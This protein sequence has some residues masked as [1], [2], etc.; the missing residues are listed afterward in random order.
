MG[1]AKTHNGFG[2]ARSVEAAQVLE[3]GKSGVKGSAAQVLSGDR[4]SLIVAT[5]ERVGERQ[6]LAHTGTAVEGLGELIQN[7]DRLVRIPGNHQ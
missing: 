2:E 6:V 5:G 3:K 4:A 1:R 7:V